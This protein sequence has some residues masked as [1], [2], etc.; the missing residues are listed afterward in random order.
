MMKTET[1]T[2]SYLCLYKNKNVILTDCLYDFC[3]CKYFCVVNIVG[4]NVL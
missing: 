1:Y 3:N 2:R 4:E